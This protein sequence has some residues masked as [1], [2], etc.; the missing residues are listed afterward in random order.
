MTFEE[1]DAAAKAIF[2]AEG[3]HY[4][5]WYAVDE[6]VRNFYREG[7]RLALRATQPQPPPPER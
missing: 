7:A 6:S 2:I 3:H 4:L 1:I 5:Y